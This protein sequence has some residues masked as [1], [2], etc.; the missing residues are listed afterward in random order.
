MNSATIKKNRNM[1][2]YYIYAH[3]WWPGFDNK[4]DA[5]HIGF[6]ETLFSNTKLRDFEITRNIEIANVLLE[7]GHP[8]L[9]MHE[10]KSWT[11]KINFIG[12]PA[13]PKATHYDVVLT[14][15]TG[16]SNIVDLPLSVAY[17]HCN[18][19]LH[20]LE[21][22]PILTS[23][24]SSFCTFIVSNPKCPTRNTIFERL[25][26]YKRVHSMGRYA[27][28]IGQ[29]I[30]YPYW[31]DAFFGVVGQYKFMICCE[32]TKMETYSTEKIVNPYMARTIPIYWG[33]PNIHNIF[34]PDSMLFLE[35]ETEEAM[36]R[37][38]HRIIELDQ[39]DDKYLEFINRPI[40]NKHNKRFWNEN[41]S[42][43]SLGKKIDEILS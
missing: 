33:T 36:Q 32:N 31:S 13:L 30:P 5:N 11:Y 27:N 43:E 14:S 1:V 18:S 2:K 16:V 38:I 22:R 4:T 8:D 39:N 3:N 42:L 41:Y 24:P 35:D 9:T 23:V 37:L 17:I 25:N 6:F 34:N 20:R 28:N 21:S 10:R 19:F 26:E 15:I 40:F 7:A 12:E 29:L